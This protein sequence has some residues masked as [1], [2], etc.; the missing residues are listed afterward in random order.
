[1]VKTKTNIKDIYHPEYNAKL[2]YWMKYRNTFNG[3]DN[4]I[5]NYLYQFTNR[6]SVVDFAF[7]RKITYC[8]AFAKADIIEIKNSIFQRLTDTIR[9]GGSP[10]YQDAIKG[11]DKG[12]DNNG[13]DM[14]GYLG[15]IILP[16]LL[17][18]GKVGIYIDKP[19]ILPNETRLTAKNKRPYLYHYKAEDI[20][21]W[22]EDSDLNLTALKLKDT[23]YDTDLDT[24]LVKEEKIQYRLYKKDN[25]NV[26][27]TFYDKDG[28]KINEEML[29]IS[30]IPFII[31]ELTHSLLVDVCNYQIALLNLE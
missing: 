5:A 3:G 6:E 17:S 8:P 20:E 26:T 22:A 10:S 30:E 15:S 14:N 25:N 21:S 24:G 7:R 4:F 19:L 27:V 11:N 31:A 23:Y 29:G 2:L 13:N 16:E 9:E 1:M 12:V 18:I 28:K